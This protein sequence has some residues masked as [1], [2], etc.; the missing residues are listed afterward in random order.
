MNGAGCGGSIQ[1]RS[2]R[3]VLREIRLVVQPRS[4]DGAAGGGGR[5]GRR[6]GRRHIGDQPRHPDVHADVRASDHQHRRPAPADPQLLR[7]SARHRRLRRRTATTPRRRSPSPTGASATCARRASTK[8]KRHAKA[9][10]LDVNDTT[11][12]TWNYEIASNWAF[13]P[14]TNGQFVTDQRFPA[15]PGMV[16]LVQKAAAAGLRGLLPD[17]PAGRAGGRDARQPD[18]GRHRRGRRL[19]GADDAERRRGRPVHQAGRRRLPG[20]PQGRLRRRDRRRR[21]VHRRSTTS[22]RPARTSSRS[23]TTSWPTSATS[24]AT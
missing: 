8:G 24:S 11:L 23:A 10:L 15:V 20:L 12:A 1:T 4:P 19:P 2:I 5:G 7:R 22:R 3:E 9:I 13:N 14:T 6:G 16:D 18:L 21:V 17:R